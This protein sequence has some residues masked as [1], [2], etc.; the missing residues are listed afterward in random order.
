MGQLASSFAHEI[1]QPLG[2]S[3]TNAQTALRILNAPQPDLAEV[4]AALEDIVGDNRRAGEIVQ[5]WRRF[6]RR[7]EPA[8]APIAVRDL[9][10]A[11]VHFVAP[12][13]RN[14]GVSIRVDVADDSLAVLA[15]RIHMQQVFVNLLLNAFDALHEKPREH[16]RVLLAAAP[17]PWSRVTLSVSDSGPG[18][19]EHLRASLFEPFLTTKPQGLGIGLAIAQTIATAHGSRLVYSDAVNGGAVFTFSLSSPSEDGHAA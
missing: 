14:Q 18:V 11:V 9:F 19:P 3:L 17:A 8:F 15:D 13:A 6:M 1:K 2:A 10:D 5:E 4:C 7:Q 12:E 16:R